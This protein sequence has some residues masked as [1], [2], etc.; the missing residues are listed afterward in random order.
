MNVESVKQI[1]T[2]LLQILG[3]VKKHGNNFTLVHNYEYIYLYICI[4]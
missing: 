2:Q 4:V 3:Y 1:N